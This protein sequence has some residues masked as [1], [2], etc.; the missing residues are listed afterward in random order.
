[1]AG[2]PVL[3]VLLL[4]LVRVKV[5]E[6]APTRVRSKAA[7]CELSMMPLALLKLNGTR[8]VLPFT[9]IANSFGGGVVLV[10]PVPVVVVVA[11]PSVVVPLVVVAVGVSEPAVIVVVAVLVVVVAN[12]LLPGALTNE[13]SVPVV[14]PVPLVAAPTAAPTLPTGTRSEVTMPMPF[15]G[16]S[17]SSG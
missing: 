12:G 17:I 10:V 16:L 5:P 2:R 8:S 3:L 1:M 15:S 11:A 6:I 7:A 14:V 4:R 9:A 13:A